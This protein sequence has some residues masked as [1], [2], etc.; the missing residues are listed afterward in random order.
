MWCWLCVCRISYNNNYFCCHQQLD[1][2]CLCSLLKIVL[3]ASP[4]PNSSSNQLCK[5]QLETTKCECE[6]V[7]VCDRA[8]VRVYFTHIRLVFEV[9]CSSFEPYYFSNDIMSTL[10]RICSRHNYSLLHLM[11]DRQH[12][13]HLLSYDIRHENVLINGVYAI[14]ST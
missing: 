7:Y 13:G 10:T 8:C 14:N 3:W 2:V 9:S 1:L 4:K 5:V 6:C 11:V 12:I